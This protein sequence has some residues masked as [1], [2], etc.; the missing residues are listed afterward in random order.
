VIQG[1]AG[2]AGAAVLFDMSPGARIRL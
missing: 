2:F 1:R